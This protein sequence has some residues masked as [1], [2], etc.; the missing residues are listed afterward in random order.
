[1]QFSQ[2]Q[3][4]TFQDLNI[5]IEVQS[6]LDEY[7]LQFIKPKILE[8][9][10]KTKLELQHKIFKTVH[11]NEFL[12]PYKLTTIDP[13]ELQK[14]LDVMVKNN[15]KVVI[16]EIS[17]QGLEQ[18]RHWGLGKFD[19]VGFLNL[20]PEH[21]DSHGSFENYKNCKL[22]LF[23]SVKNSGIAVVNGDDPNSVDFLN[24]LPKSVSQV[25]VRNRQDFEIS[26]YSST[27]YKSF[28][29]KKNKDLQQIQSK[30]MADFEIYNAVVSAK[31]IDRILI[32]HFDSRF[33]F[34]ILSGSYFSIPGRLE[35]VVQDNVLVFKK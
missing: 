1:M 6:I 19:A 13:I 10:A 31:L 27:I 33:D 35:W 5:Y 12:N 32:K 28:E 29:L 14:N 7:S 4:Q 22:K 23:Q 25:V 26:K 15:C 3:I 34:D 18:N 17:S 20:Y 24:V 11:S 8:L 21:I 16:V 9:V 30:L 2:S